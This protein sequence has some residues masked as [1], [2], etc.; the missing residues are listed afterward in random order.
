MLPLYFSLSARQLRLITAL[1]TGVL[2]GTALIVIIPEG[3]ETLYSASGSSHSHGKRD[4][5]LGTGTS[6]D[7]HA[8]GLLATLRL[9]ARR[10]DVT[11]VPVYTG[12]TSDEGAAHVEPVAEANQDAPEAAEEKEQEQEDTENDAND[13]PHDDNEFEE[14]SHDPHAWVGISLITGFI[15]MY[16]ID[17]LPRQATTT[18]QPQRFHISLNNLSFNRSASLNSTNHPSSTDEPPIPATSTHAHT[19]TRPTSTTLGLLIHAFADGIALGAS[20]TTTT[21]H[22]S[23]I[24][25]TALLLHK[26]PAAFGLTSVLLKQ[27]L[28]K[29]AARG[30]LILFSAAAPVGALLTWASAHLLGYSSKALAGSMSTEFATGVL[31]LFSGGTFLYV[32][33]HTMHENS[34]GGHEHGGGEERANGYASVPMG[35]DLGYGP[36]SGSGSGGVGRRKGEGREGVVETVVCV[37]GMLVPLLTQFGHVH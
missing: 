33:V 18:N 28:S 4:V 7:S 13:Q 11:A 15:L 5:S 35:E 32:A 21:T 27:N 23:F 29:R 24:I 31:L 30:H 34:G 17:T 26:A 36:G 9:D 1:G 20:T 2:V 14:P 3:V 22:L 12:A 16:L 6:G 8:G 25:F 19:N 37:L 10:R